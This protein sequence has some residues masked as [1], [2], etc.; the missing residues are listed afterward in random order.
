MPF[1]KEDKVL[2]KTLIELKR[3]N[4]NQLDREFPSDRQ[5]PKV[6]AKATGYTGMV[7]RRPD[8][9]KRRSTRTADN[10]DLVDEVAL[11]QEDKPQSRRTVREISRETG[12]H[13]SSVTR[14]IH[15]D[16]RLKCFKKRRA[17]EL[18]DANCKARLQRSRLLLQ[19]FP[20]HAVDFVFFSDENV[21]TVTS[22]VNSQNDGVY[23]S[24]NVKKCDIAHERLMRCRPTFSSSL[25]VSVAVSKLGCTELFFVEP[26]VKVDGRY[27]GEVLLK[28]QMLPESCVTLPVTLTRTCFS[29]TVYTPVHRSRET[30]QLLQQETPQFISLDLRPPNSPDLN[31]VDYRIWGWMRERLYKTPVRDNNELNQRLIDT[32]EHPAERRRRSH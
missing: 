22:P 15:K 11:S 7:D 14:I 12:I 6:V 30:V 19:K 20:E 3:Y 9:G 23:A 28:K 13:R 5:R 32:C 26:R 29:R 2:I 4:A 16:L 8:S 21:F 10:T 25:M 1:T 18:S 24:S 17:Q 31:P 27:Y